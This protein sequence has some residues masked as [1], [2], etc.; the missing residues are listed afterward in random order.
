[1]HD[2]NAFWTLFRKFGAQKCVQIMHSPC[3]LQ[4]LNCFAKSLRSVFLGCPLFP[5]PE[6]EARTEA[7]VAGKLSAVGGVVEDHVEAH[8]S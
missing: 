5:G 7:D 2:L 1:M 8:F 4:F 3:K 6:A